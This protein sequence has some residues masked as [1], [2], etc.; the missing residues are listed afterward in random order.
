M[1][2]HGRRLL[3]L[4]ATSLF[5]HFTI[6]LPTPPR[7][8]RTWETIIDLATSSDRNQRVSRD[9]PRVFEKGQPIHFTKLIQR[10]SDLTPRFRFSIND[11]LIL[12]KAD[13]RMEDFLR[14]PEYQ[15]YWQPHLDEYLPDF[16][17]AKDDVSGI[18]V[19]D[20]LVGLMLATEYEAWIVAG[21]QD[22]PEAQKIAHEAEIRGVCTETMRFAY[23]LNRTCQRRLALPTIMK[24]DVPRAAAAPAA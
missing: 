7:E 1:N 2:A 3:N 13:S 23:E 24:E 20:Q 15:S 8:R 4:R 14:S 19:F 10:M 16:E 21:L 11:L 12:S 22:D 9:A 18:C 5:F 17:Y 6:P